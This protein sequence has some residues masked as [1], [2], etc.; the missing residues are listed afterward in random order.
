MG[1]KLF[2]VTAYTLDRGEYGISVDLGGVFE[3]KITADIVA[4]SYRI[5]GF[6]SRVI[7]IEVGKQ[8]PIVRHGYEHDGVARKELAFYIE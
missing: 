2:M 1:K 6:L 3:N 5:K 8:Y 4:E 7:E